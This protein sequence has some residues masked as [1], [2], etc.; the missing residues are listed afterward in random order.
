MLD[1]PRFSLKILLLE[2]FWRIHLL[3]YGYLIANLTSIDSYVFR[4]LKIAIQ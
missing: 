2:I 3:N 1:L 4:E